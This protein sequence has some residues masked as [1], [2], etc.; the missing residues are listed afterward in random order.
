MIDRFEKFSLAIWE[1]SRYWNKIAS[2]EMAKYGLKAP[3]AVY[4]TSM[5]RL[6]EGITAAKLAE[7]C[8]RDKAEVSRALS[9]MEQKGL[10]RRDSAHSQYRALIKLS[11]EG[12]KLSAVI[13][14]KAMVAVELGGKGLSDEQRQTFYDALELITANLSRVSRQGLETEEISQC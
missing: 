1:I 6:E 13:T 4:F 14:E 8:S 11:E 10:V 12:K 2:D 9:L 3:F 5:A 7:L